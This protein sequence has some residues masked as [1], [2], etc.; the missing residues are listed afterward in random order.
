MTTNG[1]LLPEMAGELAA[2]GSP[3]VTVSLDSTGP[4]K[5]RPHHAHAAFARKSDGRN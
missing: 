3:R 5:V 2:A 4:G 1:Y